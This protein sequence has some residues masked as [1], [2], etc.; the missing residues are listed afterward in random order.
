[1]PWSEIGYANYLPPQIARGVIW[2]QTIEAKA[3]SREALDCIDRIYRESD[4]ADGRPRQFASHFDGAETLSSTLASLI[5]SNKSD[6]CVAIVALDSEGPEKDWT[7][8]LPVLSR[9]YDTIIGICHVERRGLR[10]QKAWLAPEFFERHFLKPA[11]LCDAVIITSPALVEANVRIS[12]DASTEELVGR[13]ARDLGCALLTPAVLDR[14]VGTRQNGAVREPQF[15][16]LGGLALETDDDYWNYC[17]LMMDRQAA[18]AAGSFGENDSCLTVVTAAEEPDWYC[19]V[20]LRDDLGD[21]CF[22]AAVPAA[23][24]E[25]RHCAGVNS[26]RMINLWRFQIDQDMYPA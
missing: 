10:Q 12:P 24:F 18:L 4:W 21:S 8:I 25:K 11:R 15:F 7:H 16:A 22:T 6:G 20:E 23:T 5:G 19:L 3:G 1:M 26:V 17:H 9:C 13:L 14:V 2:H